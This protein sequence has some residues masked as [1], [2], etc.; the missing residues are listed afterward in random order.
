M[1]LSVVVVVFVVAVVV[2]VVVVVDSS[3]LSD[4]N[5][6][7][8]DR[9][10]EKESADRGT[11]PPPENFHTEN[12]DFGNTII[13]VLLLAYRGLIQ[14]LR[15]LPA[16]VHRGSAAEPRCMGTSVL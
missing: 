6:Q 12:R 4:V 5:Y 2:V 1:W 9:G 15:A 13:A 11:C 10:V 8:C 7:H 14:V 16:D 3:R